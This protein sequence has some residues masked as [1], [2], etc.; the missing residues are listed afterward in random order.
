MEKNKKDSSPYHKTYGLVRNTIYLAKKTKKYNPIALVIMFFGCIS[1]SLSGLFGSFVNKVVIDLLEL[2]TKTQTSGVLPLIKLL[3]VIALLELIIVCTLTICNSRYW[4][5]IRCVRLHIISERI[6]KVLSMDYEALE[7]PEILDVSRKAQE[8]V[9]NRWE[10]IEGMMHNTYSLMQRCLTMVV[11][12]TGVM[13]LDR[14]LVIVIAI[15]STLQFFRHR[16]TLKKDKREVWDTLAPFWRKIDYMEQT[17]RDFDYAKDIRLFGMK[18]RLLKKQ[19]EVLKVTSD[20]QK[21]S[22]N[23]WMMSNFVSNV[24]SMLTIGAIY[25]VLIN[26]V[27]H[28]D[29]SIG[30]FTLFLGL[31]TSFSSSLAE[32]LINVGSIQQSSLKV[33]DFR[34]FMELEL[35]DENKEHITLPQC[36]KYTFEFKNV[37]FKYKGADTYALKNLNL[38]LEP[39]KRLA[40][41][42][43]NGAGKTTF[44]KLLLRLYDVTEG[45]ILLNGVNIKNYKKSDYYSLF[46][47]VFQNVETFAFPLS[48]NVSMNTPEN[49]DKDKAKDCINKAGLGD[50]LEELP[51]GIDTEILKVLSNQGI[52]LSGGQKQKLALSRALYKDAPVVVLDEPTAALDPIAEYKLYKSFDEIIGTK[53]A[54]YI[55]HRLSST[56]FC[57]AIAMFKNG[58][59]VEYGQHEELLSKNGAYAEMFAIQAQY[60]KDEAKVSKEASE[61]EE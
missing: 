28:T 36:D 37:S 50:K 61:D 22:C 27:L 5:Q 58:Q 13:V 32:F 15:L 33:D 9:Q 21:H 30:D 52:D 45:E 44:I 35:G 47:P 51:Y 16:Y 43:L 60:Y 41:V 38:T 12:F 53:S 26:S 1:G 23:L 7:T 19:A 34:S 2:Q 54:V 10:G 48:Q 18:N 29:M 6:E 3:S 56:R 57:D 11:T 8:A 14:R 59:M 46:S 20:K 39:G 17:T 31:A 40:V 4:S 25:F 24:I 55:S 49:T 42:G